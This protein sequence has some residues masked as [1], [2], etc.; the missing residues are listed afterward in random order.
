MGDVVSCQGVLRVSD[1]RPYDARAS[2]IRRRRRRRSLTALARCRW[3]RSPG[4]WSSPSSPAS[5][6]SRSTSAGGASDD[7]ASISAS[8]SRTA[9]PSAAAFSYYLQPAGIGQFSRGLHGL[10]GRHAET[11]QVKVPWTWQGL[12]AWFAVTTRLAAH[13]QRGPVTP[14]ETRPAHPTRPALPRQRRP[15]EL[16]HHAVQRLHLRRRG[17]LRQPPGRRDLR[18][19]ADRARNSDC[20]N[21]LRGTFTLSTSPYLDATIGDD[22]RHWL[23][24]GRPGLVRPRDGP[25]HHCS[26]RGP[27]VHVPRRARPGRQGDAQLRGVGQGLRPRAL[28]RHRGRLRPAQRRR[29]HLGRHVRH[30]SGVGDDQTLQY[31]EEVAEI[32]TKANPPRGGSSRPGSTRPGSTRPASTRRGSTRPGSTRPASTRRGSTRPTP[33][34]P[35]WC[36]TSRS[37]E[38]FSAAQNQTL[39]AVGQPARHLA[40]WS[41]RPPATPTATSTSGSRATTTRTSMR[42]TPSR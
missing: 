15:T 32:P 16:L 20:N 27:L 25:G 19:P 31:P 39:L 13:R 18:L 42:P 17:H 11:G 41:T 10:D 36:Q 1:A 22:N 12:H 4:R 8:R 5:G 30:G 6:R 37:S 14:P 34:S 3:R 33:T 40:R 29:P 23:G 35:S 9:R 21:F 2:I 7:A 24:R 26:G 28:R 38:A